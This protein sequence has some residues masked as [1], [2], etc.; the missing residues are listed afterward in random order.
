[1]QNL[2]IKFK[3]GTYNLRDT[4]SA[5]GPTRMDNNQFRRLLKE[6]AQQIFTNVSKKKERELVTISRH[7]QSMRSIQKLVTWASH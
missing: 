6:Q 5:I 4:P 2:F 3:Y 7:F 1:M